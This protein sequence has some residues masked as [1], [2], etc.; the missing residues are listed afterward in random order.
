LL[1]HP[2]W[3]NTADTLSNLNFQSTVFENNDEAESAFD[4]H[5]GRMKKADVEFTDIK[6]NP[7]EIEPERRKRNSKKWLIQQAHLQSLSSVFLFLKM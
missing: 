4:R 6:L 1:A 7:G 3:K 5:L 2:D